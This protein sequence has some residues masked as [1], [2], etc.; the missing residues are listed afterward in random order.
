MAKLDSPDPGVRLSILRAIN[1]LL[2]TDEG[3]ALFAD[4]LNPIS[5][6]GLIHLFIKE[7]SDSQCEIL[8][9]L[10]HFLTTFKRKEVMEVLS[11]NDAVM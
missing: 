5:I 8:E 7:C 11:K 1:H 3:P 2:C 9:L 6:Y 4:S 10:H